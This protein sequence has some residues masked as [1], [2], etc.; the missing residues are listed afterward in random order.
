MG[1]YAPYDFR[2][3]V[4]YKL[5]L[6]PYSAQLTIPFFMVITGFTYAGSYE[7]GLNWWS[8]SNMCRKI[9]RIAVPFFPA[10][11]LELFLYGRP[12]RMGV[13]LLS[14][15]Y[16]MPGSY[17]VVL[18]FQLLIL[19]PLIKCIADK[20]STV[21]DGRRFLEVFLFQCVYEG[22]AYMVD[23]DVGIYRLLVFRYVIFI[24]GGIMIY[25]KMG[26]FNRQNRKAA[27]VFFAVGIIYLTAVGYLEYQPSVIFRYP[28]WYRSAAPAAGYVV[29]IAAVL[30]LRHKFFENWLAAHR[31]AAKLAGI[32]EKLGKASYHIYVVQ[33]LWFG[34]VMTHVNLDSWR[35]LVWFPISV[36][37]CGTVGICYAWLGDVCRKRAR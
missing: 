3:G 5:F 4:L 9:R 31:K 7:R 6:M 16:Q 19:F 32:L 24:Y 30:I 26:V 36:G 28:V 13:C 23:L 8:V 33:M 29:L 20:R 2:G 18:L 22:V 1:Y 12:E 21:S 10:L 25:Q 14:G 35:K 34:I 37:M 15:G 17:Y 11:L 27:G